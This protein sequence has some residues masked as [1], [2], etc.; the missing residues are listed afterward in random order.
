M[1]ETAHRRI[2]SVS[3]NLSLG[4]GLS[5]SPPES[6][7]PSPLPIQELGWVDGL[8]R[9]VEIVV[10]GPLPAEP[11]CRRWLQRGWGASSVDCC[12]WTAGQKY[13][14]WHVARGWRDQRLELDWS[15]ASVA[16]CSQT[17]LLPARTTACI[18]R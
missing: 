2:L 4:L 10:C 11:E 15:A 7:L 12:A 14:R 13:R 1:T 18:T 17:T 9:G 8:Q 3:R 5:V 16:C 6:S